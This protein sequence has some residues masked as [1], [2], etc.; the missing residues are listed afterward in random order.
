MRRGLVAIAAL[1][2]AAWP[3]VSA[4]ENM[5]SGS[6][7]LVTGVVAGTGADAKRLG[8]GFYQYGGQASWQPTSTD[9]PYG[10]TIRWSTMLGRLY[11]ADAAQVDDKLSTVQMDLTLGVRYR[12]W[13]TPR[14]YL[15][16]RIGAQLLRAN[17]PIPDSDDPDAEMRRAFVGGIAG[18]GLDQYISSFL[19]SVDVRYGLIGD[20]PS[21]LALL[22]GFGVT[23]P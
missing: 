19:L 7:G 18:V 9:R 5:P 15:T 4:A 8:F 16:A 20:T 3:T 14:R 23:G 17:E 10:Y 11:G 1:A 12:P 22:V 6:L 2:C 21:Q 13:S